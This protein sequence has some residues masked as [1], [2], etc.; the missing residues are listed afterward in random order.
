M[1][2]SDIVE[3]DAIAE[4]VGATASPKSSWRDHLK[5]HPAADL[6]PLMSEAELREL[7]ADIKKNRQRYPVVLWREKEGSPLYLLDG[8]NRMDARA[9]VGLPVFDPKHHEVMPAHW[10]IRQG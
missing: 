2:M 8:R 5:V 9:L 6:F 10:S 1:L 4:P 7:G 3:R